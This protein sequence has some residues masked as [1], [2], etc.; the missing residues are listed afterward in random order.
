MCTLCGSISFWA[1]ELPNLTLVNPILQFLT[2]LGQA[3]L[4][5]KKSMSIETNRIYCAI[6]ENFT[7]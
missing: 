7:S 1:D 6:K 5:R 4:Q 3:M 2:Q